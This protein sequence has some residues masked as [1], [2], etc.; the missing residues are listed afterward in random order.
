MIPRSE[1]PWDRGTRS[2][3]AVLAAMLKLGIMV[4]V[5]Y[6]GT[7]SYDIVVEEDGRIIRVQV[8]A[9]SNPRLRVEPPRNQQC[10]RIVWAEQFRLTS[11]SLATLSTMVDTT[12]P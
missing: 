6:G 4:L 12:P 7:S 10:K 5:P 9:G 3:G 2:E 11:N 8:G 1:R